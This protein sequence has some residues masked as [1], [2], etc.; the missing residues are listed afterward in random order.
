PVV[1]GEEAEAMAL[2][3]RLLEAGVFVPAIRPPSVPPGSARLR[4]TVTAEHTAEHVERAL[5]AFASA[6]PLVRGPVGSDVRRT[7]RAPDARWADESP[8]GTPA[9]AERTEQSGSDVRRTFRAPDARWPD[10]SPPGTP[11]PAERTEQSGSDVRRTFRA[12]DA[13]WPDESPP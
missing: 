8:P 6:R 2:S 3:A 11:A 5:D 9:P 13:R 12:P 4:V 1:A 10:E 7:F